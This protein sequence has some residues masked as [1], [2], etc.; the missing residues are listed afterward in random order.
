MGGSG[1][2]LTGVQLVEVWLKGWLYYL[3]Y[4]HYCRN[5]PKCCS[6]GFSKRC[7]ESHFEAGAFRGS[8]YP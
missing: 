6:V 5:S 7:T 8:V 1:V 2:V 4:F 3:Y